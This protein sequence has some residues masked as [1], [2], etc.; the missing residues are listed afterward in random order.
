M[1][2]ILS[3]SKPN[4][5]SIPSGLLNETVNGWNH[6]FLLMINCVQNSQ[7]VFLCNLFDDEQKVYL[8]VQTEQNRGNIGD[9]GNHLAAQ[10][11]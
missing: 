2:C 8:C 5:N 7:P 6:G 4:S 10:I 1:N 3:G 9:N 11:I